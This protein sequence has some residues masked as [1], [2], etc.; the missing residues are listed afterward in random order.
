LSFRSQY[1]DRVIA[2]MQMLYGEGFLS[3]GG[4]AEVAELLEDLDVRGLDV[5]DLGCGIGGACLLLAGVFDAGR[6]TGVD[7]EADS[8]ARAQAAAQ[9]AGL[10]E[11]VRFVHMA[12]GPLPFADGSFDLVFTKDVVC[13]IADKPAVFAEAFRVLKPGGLLLCADFAEGL[14]GGEAARLYAD[15]VEVLRTYGLSF[16]FESPAV[17][18]NALRAAGFA[19]IALKDHMASS[20]A[21]ARRERDFALSKEAAHVREILGEDYF[22]VRVDL[23]ALRAKAHEARGLLHVHI[24]AR[25]AGVT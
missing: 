22:K 4:A 18:E 1:S 21:V 11:V 12:P 6:V 3:P 14:A 5:L 19:D 20:A 10:G 25:R 15:W 17:Y 23:S 24:R 16:H 2:G 9:K 7:I 13:H 8:I